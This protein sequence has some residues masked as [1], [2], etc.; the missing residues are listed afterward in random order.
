MKIVKFTLQIYAFFYQRLMDFPEGRFN[1]ET[2]KTLHVFESIHRII[3]VKI[4]LHNSHVTGRIYG[5]P[6]DF[7][8]MRVRENQSQF[9]FIAHKFF[10]FSIFL[11]IK[12]IRLSV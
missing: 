4:Y 9:S 6:H 1:Y 11:L 12:G 3:D 2:L 8:N 5:Y 7:C 10:S